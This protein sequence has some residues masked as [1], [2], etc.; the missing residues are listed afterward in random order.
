[1][2]DIYRNASLVITAASSPD[3]EAPFLRKQDDEWLPKPVSIISSDGVPVKMLAR[4]RHA[5]AVGVDQGLKEPPYTRAWA[6]LRR[7]GPIYKQA[8]VFQETLLARRNIHFNTGG[9]VYECKTHR[10]VQGQLPPYASTTEETL[11][12]LSPQDKWRIIVN[13]YTYRILTFSK[14]KL[15]ALSGIAITMSH[16]LGD[17][18]L[19]G[20]WKASLL[21]D[22]LWHVMP[23]ATME[24][25]TF[26]EYVAPSWSWASI[27]R[28]VV[29]SPFKSPRSLI[30]IL[31]AEVTLKG[32]NKYGEVTHGELRLRGR[33]IAC[34]VHLKSWNGEYN[35]YIVKNGKKRGKDQWFVPDSRLIGGLLD[36][37]PDAAVRRVRH[38]E[39]PPYQDFDGPSWLLCVA[40]TTWANYN[41][42][43]LLVCRSAK[44][45]DCWL[46]L[47][48]ISNLS[49]EWYD[50]GVEQELTLL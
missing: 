31:H 11:G 25:L 28:G 18:Y 24:V 43:G 21:F 29:W 10:R 38:D 44:G 15:A 4:R 46:R 45:A 39:S 22:L 36:G 20:L 26:R 47:G 32:A 34:R 17:E 27:D 30:T 16:D 1:M 41:H 35:A 7:V 23:G 33:L 37:P 49:A 12:V 42:I 19:A 14:D 3:P 48:C 6:T 2:A 9:L 13:A 40:K 50:R 5:L 8:W